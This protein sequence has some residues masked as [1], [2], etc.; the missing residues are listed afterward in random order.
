MPH[1][2]LESAREVTLADLDSRSFPVR[3]RD[4]LA[5]LATPYL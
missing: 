4:G 2:R 1:E 5:R 3:L